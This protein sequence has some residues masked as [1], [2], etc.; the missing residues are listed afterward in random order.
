MLDRCRVKPK[1]NRILSFPRKKERYPLYIVQS[2]RQYREN[3]SRILSALIGK[4][5]RTLRGHR[6]LTLEQVS[7]EIGISADILYQ[8]EAGNLEVTPS[9]L[10]IISNYFGV[11]IDYLIYQ[12]LSIEQ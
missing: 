7:E 3:R 8:L 9:M 11:V 10:V 4:N 6:Q 5:F 2:D 12:D 1:L